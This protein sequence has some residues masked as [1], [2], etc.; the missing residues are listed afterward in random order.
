M[1][2][3]QGGQKHM[4]SRNFCIATWTAPSS[5]RPENA[6]VW[7]ETPGRSRCDV[8]GRVA[9]AMKQAS[10]EATVLLY[11]PRLDRHREA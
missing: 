8:A 7:G 4:L 11:A 2:F 3:P 1:G 5:G 9:E 6:V 10:R